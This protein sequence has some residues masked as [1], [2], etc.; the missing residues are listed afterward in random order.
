MRTTLN[1]DDDV[2]LAAKELALRQRRTAGEVISEL[3]RRALAARSER[4]G[5]EAPTPVLG[6]VPFAPGV[7]VTDDAVERLREEEGI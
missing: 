6:F 3:A 4:A 7:P 5:A 2:L 1:I